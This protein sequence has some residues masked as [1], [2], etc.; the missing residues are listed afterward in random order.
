MKLDKIE[1]N[2]TESPKFYYGALQHNYKKYMAKDQLFIIENLKM[3]L[4]SKSCVTPGIISLLYNLMISASTGKINSK[5]EPEWIR[6]YTEGTQYEIYKFSAEGE[7]L[8]SSYPQLAIDIFNKFHS[9]LIAL[10]IN[11][12]GHSLI[13]L[14]PQTTETISDLIEKNFNNGRRYRRSCFSGTCRG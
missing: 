7:L 1:L 13:K 3:N 8:K 5:N 12:K 6:E 14:N 11:Y 10:E 4:L 2:K 9:L